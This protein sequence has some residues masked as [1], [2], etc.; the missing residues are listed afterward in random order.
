SGKVV[1][2]PEVGF[3]FKGRRAVLD[4]EDCPLGTD[5]VRMGLKHE[6]QRVRENIDKF[7]LGA[8]LLLRESTR[9]IPLDEAKEKSG[10]EILE[11]PSQ[12]SETNKP[13]FWDESWSKPDAITPDIIRRKIETA[14]QDEK[15]EYIEEERCITGQTAT[16]YEYVDDY[17][18][19]NKAGQ[20]F[21]N[22]NSILTPFTQYIRDNASL[23]AG[24]PGRIKYLLDA[25]S[26]SGLFTVTLSAAF[27]S[28]LGVDISG[29]GIEAARDNA[30]AN[31]LPAGRAGFAAADAAALFK[32]IP[33]P[34]RQT[35][36][37]IDP[38]R[39]GCDN[40]FLRQL[41]EYGPRRVVYVSC[42]VHTQARDVGVMVRG[43]VDGEEKGEGKKRTRYTIESIRGFDFFPQT[44]H[45]ESVAVLNLVE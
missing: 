14:Q 15:Q 37:V 29:P 1:D 2:V 11:G 3:N 6:R 44:A 16:S 33:Y 34:A 39:K 45:V 19:T 43:S 20:F 25:Y 31:N 32:D 42:N 7:K 26:G 13:L 41:L 28:S 18:F 24:A 35:L 23:P 40:V 5:I 30:T 17:V 36:M 27:L 8:T 22:N 4:I 12:Q 9:R 38:P 10:G 21:Q